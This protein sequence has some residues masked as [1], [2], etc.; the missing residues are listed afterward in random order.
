[1]ISLSEKI[2]IFPELKIIKFIF[3]ICENLSVR[4]LNS[5]VSFTNHVDHSEMTKIDTNIKM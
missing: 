2:K 3:I 5:M 1:M 4:I